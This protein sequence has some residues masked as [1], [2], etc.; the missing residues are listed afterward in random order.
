MLGLL[1]LIPAIPFVSALAL[2]VLRRSTKTGGVD[3]SRRD[4]GVRGGF[5]ARGDRVLERSARSQLL[6]AGSVD[7]VRRRRPSSGNRLLSRSALA[8]HD[9]GGGLRGFLIHLYSTEFMID[10]EGYSRFFAYMNLFV[11]S[12]L[13]L[14]LADNLLLLYLGW[15]G[16]GLCSYLLIGFWYRD[17]ANGRAGRKAFIV[18]RV[19]DTAMVIGL[20]LLFHDLGTLR[21]QDLMQRAA[22]TL[23]GWIVRRRRR[24]AAAAGWRR[25][26][27]G[28]TALA[29]VASGCHGWTHSRERLDPCGY[30][31][32]GWRLPDR[33]HARVVFACARWPSPPSRWSARQLCSSPASARLRNG[34]SN[35][36][37]PT[38]P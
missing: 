10:D 14:L 5:A 7:M 18:T 24:R 13:T 12:M 20:F 27:V 16:V 22:A 19:G 30:H 29:D 34:T 11:A 1:W 28:A 32:D 37:W 21:I 25:G 3:R 36:Y 38:P 4:C 26:Q 31:G 17:P 33:P 23:A 35:A 2:A 9:A 6:H 8:H 15:E